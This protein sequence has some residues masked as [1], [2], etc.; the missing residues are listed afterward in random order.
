M[1]HALADV[2]KAEHAAQTEI[3]RHQLDMAA[4]R[5]WNNDKRRDGRGPGRA[6]GVTG[7][8]PRALYFIIARCCPW[9]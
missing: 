5:R 8:V 6:G 1:E 2:I 3:V 7:W 4:R 9:L